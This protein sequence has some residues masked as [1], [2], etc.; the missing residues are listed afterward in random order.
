MEQEFRTIVT[1]F[2]SG[3]EQRASLDRFP[4]RTA[5]LLYEDL[6][7]SE[8]DTLYNFYRARRGK[9]ES[10]YYFDI[11]SHSYTD[12][13]V[14]RGDGADLTFEMPSVSTVGGSLQVYVDSVLTAVTLNAGTGPNGEDQI[15]FTGAPAS[16]ALITANLTGK[17][18]IKCRFL[19]DKM[20]RDRFTTVLFKSGLDLYEVR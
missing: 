13:Y 1:P 18:K 20:S 10:F 4:K 8:I 11:L 5:R 2:R 6:T 14:A 17:L 16:G 15:V 3:T 7:S 19:E 9:W 12:E